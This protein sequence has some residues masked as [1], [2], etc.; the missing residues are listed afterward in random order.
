[1]HA[2]TFSPTHHPPTRTHARTHT[3]THPHA[4]TR[5][6]TH[7]RAHARTRARTHTHTHTN[8]HPQVRGHVPPLRAGG[9]PRARPRL[10]TR[11][12]PGVCLCVCVCV[13]VCQCAARAC[14]QKRHGMVARW[15]RRAATA[16]AAR[17]A[18]QVGAAKQCKPTRVRGS[19]LLFFM[20]VCACVR[21]CVRVFVDRHI[22]RPRAAAKRGRRTALADSESSATRSGP[23][24][25]DSTRVG[26]ESAGQRPPWRLSRPGPMVPGAPSCGAR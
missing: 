18:G 3:P 7:A 23:D 16:R 14:V 25:S 5:T 6:H 24:D 2:K 22:C 10:A 19:L 21:A 9:G 20:C 1:M 4:R 15:L 12:A 11:P 26:S 8:T 17:A 13:C